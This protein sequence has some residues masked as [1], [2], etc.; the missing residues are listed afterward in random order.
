MGNKRVIR[1]AILYPG[2][3]KAWQNATVENNR[4]A[5]LFRTLAELGASAEPAVYH[6][7]FWQEAQQQ[8]SQVDAVLV[9]VNPIQDGHDRT[10][11][12]QML[13]DTANK[14]IFVSAHPDIIL[15]MGT[16]DCSDSRRL[17]TGLNEVCYVQEGDERCERDGSSQASSRAGWC[18]KS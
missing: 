9:W 12:D 7:D 13:R 4:F 14:G 3:Y 16:K 17:D 1:I 10:I 18:W 5:D 15:K 11:L 2:D 8:I 6:P